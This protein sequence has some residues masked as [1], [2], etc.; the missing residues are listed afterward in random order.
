MWIDKRLLSRL[1]ADRQ[2]EH[3][4]HKHTRAHTHTHQASGV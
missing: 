2:S 1:L 3:M 4:F